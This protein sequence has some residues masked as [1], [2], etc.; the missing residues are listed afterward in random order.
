MKSLLDHGANPN[1]VL[2]QKVWF[3]SLPQDRTWVDPS[4]ATAFWR[5]SQANDVEGMRLL[6]KAGADPKLPS[7]EGVTP[8]MVAAGLGWAPNFSRNAPDAWMASVKYCLELGLDVNAKNT[9][10]YTALHGTAFIGNNE[11]VQFL[12]DKGADVRAVAN[13][14][15][16]VAD[17]ANGPIEHSVLHP[18]TVALLEKLGSQNS[19]NCRSDTCVVAP[20]QQRPRDEKPKAPVAEAK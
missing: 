1:A 8:L 6:V 19:N 17:M 9:K 3:R 10:G 7:Q 16:T 13:D 11:L 18:D 5:A 2:S 4:G 15:N 12:V 14:K 20:K